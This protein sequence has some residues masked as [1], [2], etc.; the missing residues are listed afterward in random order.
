MRLFD[1]RLPQKVESK[2]NINWFHVGL[3]LNLATLILFLLFLAWS[4]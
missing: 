3:V 1:A 2:K 4:G